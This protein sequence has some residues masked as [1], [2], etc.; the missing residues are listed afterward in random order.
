MENQPR[1]QES[2]N[3]PTG[4]DEKKLRNRLSQQAFRRRQNDRIRELEQR[5][6]DASRTDNERVCHLE[7]ENMLLRKQLSTLAS[8]LEAVQTTLRGLSNMVN[9][10]LQG[11]PDSITKSSTPGQ[12]TTEGPSVNSPSEV[13]REILSIDDDQ[14]IFS[15]SLI[16]V[17]LKDN[18]S[19]SSPLGFSTIPLAS[20]SGPQH[21]D[22][23]SIDIA[24]NY[25]DFDRA[26][27]GHTNS[28]IHAVNL[29]LEF[30]GSPFMENPVQGVPGIWSYHYQMGPHNYQYIMANISSPGRH[31]HSSNS[32]FSDH[33]NALH[34]CIKRAWNFSQFSDLL[35][36]KLSKV[37]LSVSLMLSLFN[38]LNRPLALSWYTPT[39]FYHHITN[40]T[41]WQLCPSREMYMQLPARYRPSALQLTETY[42]PI[43]D[44]C[45][46]PSIRDKLILLHSANP[47]IDQIICDIA[48]AY[49]VETDISKLI[50]H[51]YPEIG[52]VR[53]WE[54]I[55]A[56][57]EAENE[58]VDFAQVMCEKQPI[59]QDLQPQPS[60][61]VWQL[62]APNVESLFGN[63]NYARLAFKELHMDDGVSHYKLDPL[64]FNKYPELFDPEEEA[65]AVGTPIRLSNWTGI[66][67]PK[68]LDDATYAIYRHFVKWT[69]DVIISTF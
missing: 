28:L 23:T 11:Y 58:Q 13:D 50:C 7:E 20:S 54:L 5:L 65:M 61:G 48:T 26:K 43:I 69:S 49:V 29:P 4:V 39:K 31:I 16:D 17:G 57:G 62:P 55:Q 18:T 59:A 45:P 47:C 12:T 10:T 35:E 24:S 19:S 53:V 6:K 3:E 8:K 66:P 52:Y 2:R 46:F 27:L 32:I 1:A 40:L 15:A 64:L 22:E 60:T 42:P 56:M 21:C 68:A 9:S 33:I 41:L 36:L 63:E 44:W 38:S 14:H 30:H 25:Q 37:R 34:T 67:V 51:D